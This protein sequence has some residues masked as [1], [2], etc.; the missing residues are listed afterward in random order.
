MKHKLSIISFVLLASLSLSGCDFIM[1]FFESG[2]FVIG[3]DS[4]QTP[5][6][7]TDVSTPPPGDTNANS[8]NY[9]YGDYIDR[10]VYP[11]SCT[12]SLGKAKLLV[13]PVWF[14]DSNSYIAS[15]KRNQVRED[16]Q[17]A[18]F[19]DETATGWRS[20]KTYYEEESLGKLTIE[21]TVSEWYECGSSVSNYAVDPATDDSGAPKTSALVKAATTW[22]FANHPSETK[23]DYD[24]DGDG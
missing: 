19:G 12:P 18:Y 13:I 14:T 8:A 3:G 2:F 15:N 6:R 21:G 9:I 17:S 1:Q 5:P 20:V 22:F 24:Q 7:I 4:A 23:T 11:L 10:N 16:I